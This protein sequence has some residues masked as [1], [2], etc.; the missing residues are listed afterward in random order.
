MKYLRY[1]QRC[2]YLTDTLNDVRVDFPVLVVREVNA[3]IYVTLVYE[4]IRLIIKDD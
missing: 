1:R 2:S 4:I 3:A